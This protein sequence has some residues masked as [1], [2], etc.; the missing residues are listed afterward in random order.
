MK[1]II[2]RLLALGAL[3]P[4]LALAAKIPNDAPLLQDGNTVV[5]AADFEAYMARVPEERRAEFRSS[6]DRIAKVVDGLFVERSLADKAKA[7]GLDKDPLVQRRLRE[8]QEAI[9]ADV[10]VT[11][12]KKQA[13]GIDLEQRALELYKAEPKR[14]TTPELVKVQSILVNLEGRTRDAALARANEVYELAKSGKEDFLS[15]AA[16]YS[17]DPSLA[18]NAGNLPFSPPSAFVEPVRDAIEGMAAKGEIRGPIESKY[19]F[20]VI[21]LV[22]RKKPERLP[23]EAVKKELIAAERQKIENE[24]VQQAVFEIRNSK[25]AV[26][27]PENVEALIVPIDAKVLDKAMAVQKALEKKDQNEAQAEQAPKPEGSPQP[28]GGAKP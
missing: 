12:L 17:D 9:L 16:R 27:H 8:A 26:S 24:R 25:S 21:R 20:H 19:G 15:L 7:E 4:A 11:R 18:K 3:V 28:A 1:T 13:S 10:Y 22:E 14:S 23:F 5:E 2:I 6:Y